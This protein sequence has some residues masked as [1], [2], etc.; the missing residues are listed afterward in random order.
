M[1]TCS[2]YASKLLVFLQDSGMLTAFFEGG[3]D[4]LGGL[5]SLLASM[6]SSDVRP[7]T[8]FFRI[9]DILVDDTAGNSF[10]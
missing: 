5:P 6:D 7:L 4:A 9:L 3:F 2:M 8:G 1:S 10:N